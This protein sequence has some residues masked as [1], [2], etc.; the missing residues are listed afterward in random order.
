ME[1]LLQPQ[2]LCFIRLLPLGKSFPFHNKQAFE[3]Q[4]HL[5]KEEGVLS[6]PPPFRYALLDLPSRQSYMRVLATLP[7]EARVLTYMVYDTYRTYSFKS[8]KI[9]VTRDVK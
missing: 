3:T 6:F 7:A 4:A 8:T 1:I 5:P 9:F 2:L